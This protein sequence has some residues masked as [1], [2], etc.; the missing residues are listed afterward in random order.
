MKTFAITLL[1]SMGLA[2]SARATQTNT[3]S[4]QDEAA[5]APTHYDF[6]DDQVEGDLQRPDG[7][8]VTALPR[9]THKSLIEIPRSFLPELIRT[10]ED[11]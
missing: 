1:L 8:L 7:A 10:F 5:P 11:L 9:A 4:G 6:E 2:G 3:N